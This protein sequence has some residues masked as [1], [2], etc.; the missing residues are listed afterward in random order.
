MA[1]LIGWIIAGLLC[2][3]VVIALFVP[4]RRIVSYKQKPGIA[5]VRDDSRQEKL[6]DIVIGN[7]DGDTKLFPDCAT[8]SANIYREDTAKYIDEDDP[9]ELG[10]RRLTVDG[11]TKVGKWPQRGASGLMYDIWRNEEHHLIVLVFRG[12]VP[13]ISS[14]LANLHVIFRYIPFIV[15]QYDQ[16]KDIVP[17]IV[18]DLSKDG[19]SNEF[20][21]IATGHSLGG[22][23]AQHAL[24]LDPRIKTAFAFNSSPF[25]GWSDLEI[26]QRTD[27]A[28]ETT[29]YRIHENGEVLEFL[30][31]LMKIS[32]VFNPRPNV[33]PY[34]VEYRFN[35]TTGGLVKQHGIVPLA[36]VLRKTRKDAIHS[37]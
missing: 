24:Y 13:G 5:F 3:V 32:Y 23:L 33:N 10:T 16:I 37:Q 2:G 27:N 18:D 6:D 35:L 25:T 1:A 19:A 21:F 8:L 29:I 4:I 15:D 34:F 30:R 26:R 20:R 11:W 17:K 28:F 9:E 31:L 12:T 14:W 36:C 22:G 7:N